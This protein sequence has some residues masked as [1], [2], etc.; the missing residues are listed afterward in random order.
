MSNNRKDSVYDI[1]MDALRNINSDNGIQVLL[2]MF[3][4]WIVF[5]VD[6]SEIESFFKPNPQTTEIILPTQDTLIIDTKT[7][8]IINYKFYI[9]E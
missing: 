1:L 9:T 4:V 2:I 5:F 6:S 8:S 7:F 3:L